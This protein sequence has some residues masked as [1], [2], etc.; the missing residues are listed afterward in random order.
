[1]KLEKDKYH[2]T[3]LIRGLYDR[4]STQRKECK[5]NIKTGRGTK[6]K[7][8]INMENK[9][10]VTGGAVGGGWA[11]WVRGI[12]ESTTEIIVAL[13]TNLDVNLKKIKIKLKK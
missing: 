5:N 10:E 6:Q 13:Y 12:K 11:K 2:M 1:M 3:L 7:R 4:T 8:L 9:L